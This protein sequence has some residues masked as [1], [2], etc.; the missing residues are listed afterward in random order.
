MSQN[1][2]G[3]ASSGPGEK[4]GWWLD[5]VAKLAR[6]AL[7]DTE[8]AP[9]GGDDSPRAERPQGGVRPENVRDFIFERLAGTP[10]ADELDPEAV[11]HFLRHR[12]EDY[13]LMLMARWE[14]V[15]RDVVDELLQESVGA[16]REAKPRVLWQ[17]MGR[18]EEVARFVV[19]K[20]VDASMGATVGASTKAADERKS[21][22]PKTTPPPSKRNAQAAS[23]EEDDDDDEGTWLFD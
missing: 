1:E 8:P 23:P 11:L 22:T 19:E 6:Q 3:G 17:S 10:L 2:S 15:A 5:G 9:Q 20:V 4:I 14:M 18:W 13:W 16:K 21:P 12:A 7:T